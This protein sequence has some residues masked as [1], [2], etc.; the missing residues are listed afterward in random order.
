MP[1]AAGI[2]GFQNSGD[3]FERGYAILGDLQLGLQFYELLAVQQ[4]SCLLR[5]QRNPPS[6][7]LEM[8]TMA[9]RRSAGAYTRQTASGY[10][11]SRI[12]SEYPPIPANGCSRKSLSN[13]P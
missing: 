12:L 10:C 6:M 1:A 11:L 3:I 5:S 2:P 13:A 7:E 8:P 4:T 9:G